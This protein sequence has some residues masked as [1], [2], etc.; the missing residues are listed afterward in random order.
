MS[1]YYYLSCEE[2]K[3]RTK[4]IVVVSCLEKDYLD[5][6]EETVKFLMNHRD[7]NLTFFSEYNDKKMDY[8]IAEFKNGGPK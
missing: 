8:K 5:N 4:K 3:V 7:H 2:C 6:L 1:I